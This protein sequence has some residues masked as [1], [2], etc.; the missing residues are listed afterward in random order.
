[1]KNQLIVKN[2]IDTLSL[3][4]SGNG[5]M[6]GGLLLFAMFLILVVIGVEKGIKGAMD[7]HPIVYQILDTLGTLGL[8]SLSLA[9][10]VALNNRWKSINNS[11]NFREKAYQMIPFAHG[12]GGFTGSGEWTHYPN[13]P[14]YVTGSSEYNDTKIVS[15]SYLPTI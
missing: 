3:L 2:T 10:G 4:V 14:F 15:D 1:M 5:Y 8:I 7:L 6:G 13:H 11:L 9:V 12:G